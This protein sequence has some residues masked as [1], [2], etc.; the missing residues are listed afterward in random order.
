MIDIH[1]HILPGID[2]GAQDLKTALKMARIAVKDGVTGMIATPHCQ[3][4]IYNC[5]KQV[6][7]PACEQFNDELA[8]VG[9]PLIVYPGAE[10][11]ICPELLDMYKSDELLTLGNIGKTVL[12]ELPERFIPE[13]MVRLVQQLGDFGLATILAHPE[14]NM[15]IV[16]RPAVL[17]GFVYAGAKLQITAGSVLGKFGRPV[18]LFSE[19]LVRDGKIHHLASDSHGV[20]GRV[21][22]LAKAFKRIVKIAGL[23][24]AEKIARNSEDVLLQN[25]KIAAWGGDR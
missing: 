17:D 3:D 12:L 6:I 9:I 14:R 4:G 1:S 11:R 18:K 15:T 25:T 13:A 24:V 16:A 7:L 23:D 8:R 20:R 21:P 19:M 10:I 5:T 22:Q 2:D